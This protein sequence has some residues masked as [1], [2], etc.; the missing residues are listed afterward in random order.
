[1]KKILFVLCAVLLLLLVRPFFYVQANTEPNEIIYLY[2]NKNQLTSGNIQELEA[3]G[4][5]VTG[6]NIEK[7]DNEKYFYRY[8]AAYGFTDYVKLPL[9]IAG[10]E[11]Y[12]IDNF[13]SVVNNILTSAETP[14]KDLNSYEVKIVVYFYSP[15]CSNCNYL[16]NETDVFDRLVDGGVKLVYVNILD[17]DN[18]QYFQNYVDVYGYDKATTPFMF[19]G[20]KYYHSAKIIEDN[21]EDII[22]NAKNPLLDVE[23]KQLDTSKYQGFV[24]F[25]LILVAGLIDGVNPCAIAM[26]ILFISLLIGVSSNR[27]T[28]IAVATSYILGLF[29]MY[30]LTGLFLMNIVNKLGPYIS[31]LSFYINLF[32]IVFFL[33][34]AFF[35]FYDYYMAKKQEYGKIKNQLPKRIQKFNKKVIKFFTESLNNKNNILLYIIPFVLGAIISLTEFLCTGQVYLPVILSLAHSRHGISGILLLFMYNFMF[36]LPLIVISFVVIRTQSVMQA[37]NVVREKMHLIKLATSLL[38]FGMAIYYILIV[39]GVI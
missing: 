32:I 9:I 11:Y 3:Q 39:T 22:E 34:F 5:K 18:L 27:R 10:N 23:F 7:L 31:N 24:G 25:L 16:E 21:V 37:S 4:L 17:T 29:V 28:I 8:Q 38:F 26:L 36:V 2:N 35:N 12:A 19:A 30:F 14:L 20:S 15:S 1:M 33:I 13:D 6:I